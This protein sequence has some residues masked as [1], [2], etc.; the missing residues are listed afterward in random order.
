M[1]TKKNDQAHIEQKNFTPVRKLLGYERID[2]PEA[3]SL[4]NDLY[5]NEVRLLM[6]FFVPR[7]KLLSK[8]R[9]AS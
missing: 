6:N 2:A 7:A 9:V 5:R 8:E 3:L 4:V 1:P